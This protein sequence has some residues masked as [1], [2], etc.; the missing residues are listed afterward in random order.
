MLGVALLDL[1]LELL[2]G[3][4][5]GLIEGLLLALLMTVGTDNLFAPLRWTLLV[6]QKLLKNKIVC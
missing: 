1:V 3:G 5:P 4:L 2:T 6:G